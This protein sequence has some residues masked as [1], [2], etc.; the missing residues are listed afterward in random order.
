LEYYLDSVKLDKNADTS[1]LQVAEESL[2][3]LG[4]EV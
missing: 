1:V 3:A 2:Q 4:F